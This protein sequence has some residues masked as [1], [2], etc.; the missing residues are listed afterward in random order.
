MK[1]D[2]HLINGFSNCGKGQQM[3]WGRASASG[4][5]RSGCK[6]GTKQL[7]R[8]F[9]IFNGVVRSGATV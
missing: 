7:M 8:A 3:N 2:S 1:S 5:L 4:A 9:V 6:L